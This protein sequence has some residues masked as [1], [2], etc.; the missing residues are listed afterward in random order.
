MSI[1]SMVNQATKH[2]SA[3]TEQIQKAG[4]ALKITTAEADKSVER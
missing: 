1:A 4:W 2:P 3:D